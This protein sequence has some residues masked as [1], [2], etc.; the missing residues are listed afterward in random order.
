MKVKDNIVVPREEIATFYRRHH[1]RKLAFFGSVLTKCDV[2][3]AVNA[4]KW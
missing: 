4:R 1:I 2:S 3:P